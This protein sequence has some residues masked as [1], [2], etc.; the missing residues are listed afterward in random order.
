MLSLNLFLLLNSCASLDKLDKPFCIDETPA[1]GF[2][3]TLVSGKKFHINDTEL[4]TDENGIKKTWNDMQLGI[5]KIPLETF[6]AM[7]KY[8]IDECKLSGKCD[9]NIT[10]WD[11]NMTTLELKA[12]G[13]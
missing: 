2:C 5:I 7:K 1:Q 9:S 4:Y 3:V 11:R 12:G 6:K 8:L 10:T 13:N